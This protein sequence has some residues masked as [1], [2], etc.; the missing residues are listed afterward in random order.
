MSKHFV[1]LGMMFPNVP[2][3]FYFDQILTSLHE[4]WLRYSATSW[5]LHTEKTPDD[6]ALVLQPHL[7]QDEQMLI[8]VVDMGQRNG[9]LAQWIWAWIISRHNPTS[10]ALPGLLPYLSE[11]TNKKR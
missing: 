2:R 4:D 8:V 9:W 6:L 1:H 3:T 5:L 11:E 10:P 7:Q